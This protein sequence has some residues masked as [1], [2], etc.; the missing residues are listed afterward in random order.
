MS[1]EARIIPTPPMAPS[2]S[3]AW[4]RG[5]EDEVAAGLAALRSQADLV[6]R[7]GQRLAQ[8]LVGGARLLAAGN[9]GSA[10]ESQHLTSELVGRFLAERRPLSA[11]ALCAESSSITAIVND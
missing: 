6:D 8:D 7:W 10:A 11:I 4:L 5:H 2:G 3:L 1:I 9:G